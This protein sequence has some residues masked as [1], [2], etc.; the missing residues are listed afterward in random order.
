MTPDLASMADLA[1]E[2]GVSNTTLWRRLRVDAPPSVWI[3]KCRMF[4]WADAREWAARHR[5]A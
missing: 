2:A 3:G 1:S 4:R 5:R